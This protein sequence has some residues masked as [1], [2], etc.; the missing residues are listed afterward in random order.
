VASSPAAAPERA[1]PDRIGSN[2]GPTLV[3]AGRRF[4]ASSKKATTPQ[5]I[6][7]ALGARSSAIRHVSLMGSL[8]E[9]DLCALDEGNR[10]NVTGERK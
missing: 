3:S 6:L 2:S 1:R 7:R 9:V 4:A 10:R 8:A 5:L